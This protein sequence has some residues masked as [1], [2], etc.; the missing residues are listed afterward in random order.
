MRKKKKAAAQKT[1]VEEGFTR[2]ASILDAVDTARAFPETIEDGM[3]FLRG[4]QEV[5]EFE[6]SNYTSKQ[7]KSLPI[8]SPPQY[9]DWEK[10]RAESPGA[11]GLANA[12]EFRNNLFGTKG[13]ALV[14]VLKRARDELGYPVQEVIVTDRTDY[15]GWRVTLQPPRRG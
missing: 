6:V 15:K 2:T 14:A 8:D 3:V 5:L 7:A 13:H 1:P 11:Q 10:S 9:D 4:N 12:I